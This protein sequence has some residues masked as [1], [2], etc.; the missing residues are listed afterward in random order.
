MVEPAWLSELR[1]LIAGPTGNFAQLAT[2]DTDGHPRC[3]TVVVREIDP[4]GRLRFTADV[5]S[6]KVAQIAAEP[7]AELCWYLIGAWRQFRLSGRLA[8]EAGEV[9]ARL[10]DEMSDATRSQFASR[11]D[12]IVYGLDVAQV[13]TLDITVRPF[14][15]AL[16]EREGLSW[17]R[18][19]I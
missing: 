11:A 5:S 15:R 16:H 14:A 6:A 18:R 1:P 12:F 17:T 8:V 13:E 7:R 4:D 19:A 2:V 10:W 3:R 9:Q